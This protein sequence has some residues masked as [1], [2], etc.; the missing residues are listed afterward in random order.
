MNTVR[1]LPTKRGVRILQHGTVLSEVLKKPGATHSVVDVMAAGIRILSPCPEVALL[2]FSGGGLIGP[3]R[4]MRGS[5]RI[6]A[7]DMDK[8][9]FAV[10][11]KYCRKWA[12][13]VNLHHA[14]AAHWLRRTK[15][16]YDHIVVDLSISLDGEVQTPNLVWNDL[17]RLV[18]ERLTPHGTG[19]FNLLRPVN[20]SWAEGL[21]RVTKLFPS[22]RIVSLDDFENRVVFVGKL[23]GTTLGFSHRMRS[24]LKEIGSK[25]ANR[26]SVRR[27]QHRG[28]MG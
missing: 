22:A 26:I 16:R 25:Q 10:F 6:T 5:H 2:G 20:L 24:L 27:W 19:T 4:A 7:L 17:P 21:A 28:P 9:G 15:R 3:L 11:E 18:F 1:T 12:G 8:S 23:I 13:I 14:E